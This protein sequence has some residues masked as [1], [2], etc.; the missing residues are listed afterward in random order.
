MVSKAD[1]TPEEWQKLLESVMLA[2]MSVTAADPSGLWG[3]IKEA[4]AS[5]RSIAEAKS[6]KTANPLV[7]AIAAD[8]ETSEGRTLARDGLTASLK[9]SSAKD[10]KTKSIDALREIGGILEAKAPAD[11]PAV[12]AWLQGVAQRAAEAAKEG[13]FLGFGGVQVSDAEKAALDEVSGALGLKE[14]YA[15]VS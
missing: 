1:F 12:K 14:G 8:L 6:D 7:H 11:A 15:H 10:I 9:G 2:G 5:A 13:G 4:A 3:L